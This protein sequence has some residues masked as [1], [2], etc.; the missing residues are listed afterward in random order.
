[1]ADSDTD[2]RPPLLS[3]TAALYLDF[4]GTLADIA[5][6]PDGVVVREPLPS[7]LLALRER[8]D[9][10]VAVIT[11]RR[12]ADV[13]AMIAPARLPG[14][15]LH[16]AEL[17]LDSGATTRAPAPAELAAIANALHER[18]GADPRLIIEDKGATIALHYRLAPERAGEC[19]AV[20]RAL[21]VAPSLEIVVGN[22]VAEARLR[23]VDKGAALRMLAASAPFSRRAPV[24]VGDDATD[25]DG[26]RAAAALGGCGVKVGRGATAARYR[27]GRVAEVHA[28][29]RASLAALQRDRPP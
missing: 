4:D 2:A 16:G 22:M 19:V 21:A 12:L 5:P 26:F 28:W 11:G 18:L 9:G 20:L 7:L 1:M 6:Q 13:D 3:M 27:I 14:A 23:G 24:F 10:A 25:E 15:G 17:R 29:L 8:L